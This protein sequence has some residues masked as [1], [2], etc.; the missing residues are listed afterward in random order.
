MGDH[1]QNFGLGEVDV[2][3]I[4]DDHA[5]EPGLEGRRTEPCSES[6]SQPVSGWS[7]DEQPH[8]QAHLLIEVVQVR[9]PGQ[10]VRRYGERDQLA[11]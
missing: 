11:V 10:V 9:V 5:V 3:E 1:I 7:S 2:L 6:I 8:I 4:V